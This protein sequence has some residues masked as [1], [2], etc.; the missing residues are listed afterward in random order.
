MNSE[1]FDLLTD[2][3]LIKNGYIVVIEDELK[4]RHYYIR[5]GK[6]VAELKTNN[7]GNIWHDSLENAI[8]NKKILF[9]TNKKGELLLHDKVTGE[10]LK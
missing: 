6:Q 7:N 10:D 5:I 4:H 8:K 3:N 1:R 2:T 9:I